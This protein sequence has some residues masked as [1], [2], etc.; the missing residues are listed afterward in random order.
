M[1]ADRALALALAS[2]LGAPL[3]LALAYAALAAADLPAWQA[4]AGQ[5]RF[6]TALGLSLWTGLAS[7]LLSLGLA[8]WL[9]ARSFP[10]RHWQRLV[11]WLGPMLALPH[12]AFGIGLVLLIAPGGWL[13]RLASPWATGMQQVP[14]WPTSQDPWGLGLIAALVAKEVPFRLWA[15]AAQRQRPDLAQRLA[16]ELQVAHSLGY[17]HSRAWRCV[18]APQLGPTLVG[19]ALAVL[20]YGLTTVDL[21][22]VAGPLAPPT[23]AVLAWGWL[24]DADPRANAQGAAA[25]WVLALAVALAAALLWRLSRLARWRR[26]RSDGDRGPPGAACSAGGALALLA[27]LYLAVL[28]ALALASVAGVWQFPALLPQV[29]STQAWTSVADSSATLGTTLAL[30]LCSSLAALLWSVAWLETAPPRWDATLRRLVYLPLLLPPLLWVLGVHALALR[31]GLDARWSG[32]WLAHGL[33][34]VPYT[35]IALGPA[36]R[37][38]DPRTEQVAATLGRSRAAF[39]LRVKWPLL[40]AALASALAVGFAVSVAQYLPTLFIGAGRF[41]SV[42][43]EAIT[44]ASGGQRALASAYAA[45]QCA[46]PLLGFA[47]AARVG[48]QRRFAL[49]GRLRE[50]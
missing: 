4:L 7:S 30:G 20:A 37:G 28:L 2:L 47:L 10:G 32:L 48:R 11:G 26:L 44:R 46:L 40:R 41:S 18:L 25:A 49:S 1:A 5:R 38:F 34:C 39:L 14:P 43:T 21:A 23:L 15:A 8:A 36:Y 24:L 12:A 42:S 17:S 33:A 29:F 13:M 50:P 9:L 19:P 27:A 45:L 3:V 35:L 31:L 22:L 6:W 16:R